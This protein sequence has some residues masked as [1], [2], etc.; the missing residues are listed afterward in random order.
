[1]T[2]RL[3]AAASSSQRFAAQRFSLTS[4]TWRPDAQGLAGLHSRDRQALFDEGGP[5]MVQYNFSRLQ[6]HPKSALGIQAKLAIGEPND[7]YEQEAD[8]IAKRVMRTS[9]PEAQHPCGCGGACSECQSTL[10]YSKIGGIQM[11]PT[12]A[13]S[14]AQASAPPIINEVLQSSGQPLDA[15]T[16]A[17]FEPRFGY[18]FSR[19]RIHADAKA[20]ESARAVNALAYTVGGNIV[21]G[22]GQFAPELLAHELAHVVQQDIGG[23]IRVAR[24]PAPQS[25]RSL[26]QRIADLERRQML[27]EKQKAVTNFYDDWEGKFDALFSSWIRAVYRIAGGL[28][29]AGTGFKTAIDDQSKFDELRTQLILYGAAFVFA[30][31]FEPLV[32]PALGALGGKL[33][34]V[35]KTLEPEQLED[36]SIQL[37]G[38]LGNLAEPAGEMLK[39]PTPQ[40]E[41]ALKEASGLGGQGAMGSANTPIGYFFSNAELLEEKRQF[42][43]E[44]INMW[45]LEEINTGNLATSGRPDFRAIHASL[46]S[47]AKGVE[48]MKEP[49]DVA[50]I[51]ESHIWA[52]W[53]K[54]QNFRTVY[55]PMD[56]G[57]K[58]AYRNIPNLGSYVAARLNAIGV[59]ELAAVNLGE[60]FY[61]SHTPLDWATKLSNWAKNYKESIVR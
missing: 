56:I 47:T 32:A 35:M 11:K 16:R 54:Q 50:A 33:G 23:D 14:V 29:S 51:L 7:V 20:G 60:H 58:S 34:T 6:I 49:A 13:P 15:Q 3:A 42:V 2:Q 52:L 4:P 38:G 25:E 22:A 39:A 21:F 46:E 36:P 41:E 12:G 26:D 37:V 28:E 43:N 27:D 8:R 24:A 5:A 44:T 57:F 45:R 53:I 40:T 30:A 1:M 61:S 19:V 31:A 10:P 48:S 59:S 18:D 17:H 55:M 9:A